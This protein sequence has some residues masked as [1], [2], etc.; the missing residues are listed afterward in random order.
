MGTNVKCISVPISAGG[1][2]GRG[3]FCQPITF[4]MIMSKRQEYEGFF[5]KKAHSL[6]ILNAPFEQ[7][8]SSVR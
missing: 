5:P 4:L 3:G 6:K 1:M 7:G 8:G 2:W